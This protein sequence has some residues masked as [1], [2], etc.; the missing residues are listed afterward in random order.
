MWARPPKLRNGHFVYKTWAKIDF[1]LKN[2]EKHV[3]FMGFFADMIENDDS[4]LQTKFGM[5]ITINIF[6][7]IQF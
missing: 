1:Y 3:N 2:H 6:K 7:I 4:N 5:H